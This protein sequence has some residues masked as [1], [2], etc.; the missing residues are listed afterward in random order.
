M[1]RKSVHRDTVF[2]DDGGASK[3]SDRLQR[4]KRK[5]LLRKLKY[6]AL[7]SCCILFYFVLRQNGDA[8]TDGIMDRRKKMRQIINNQ[9]MKRKDESISKFIRKKRNEKRKPNIE[10]SDSEDGGAN[11]DSNP[12]VMKY[13]WTTDSILPPV[14]GQKEWAAKF[15]DDN[16]K[17]IREKSDYKISHRR[18]KL[19]WEIEFEEME[20]KPPRVD[21][22]QHEY[23]YPEIIAQPPRGG[24]YPPME[25]L[26]ELLKRWPQ[27]NMD[28]PPSP[29]VEKLQHFDFNDEEQMKIAKLYRDLEF[30]F[31]LTNVPEL[32]AA[33]AKWTDD[34]LSYH[35]D[36]KRKGN[37]SY[38]EIKEKYSNIPPSSGHAQESVD[39][40]FAF[41]Q[42]RNWNTK[43]MGQPPT[44]D[45]DFTYERW[46]RHAKYADTVRLAQNET[47][48]YWQ[49]GASPSERTSPKEEW[50]MISVDLP[51]FSDTNPNFISFNPKE[52]KGIQCRFGE[53]GVAAATHYD[54]GRNMV[55]MITGA[56]RYVLAPP[57]E[58]GKVCFV[59]Q[60]FQ[61]RSNWIHKKITLTFYLSFL[62]RYRYFQ[63]AS[64]LQAFLTQL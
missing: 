39:S 4:R 8:V 44:K 17:P 29:Y 59:V 31:K 32:I 57:L 62:A 11:P 13:R 1:P 30:P 46:A 42:A 64:S 55:G 9:R 20:Q 60:S 19:P 26:G 61:F 45:N 6:P 49:S 3:N 16:G 21:Y 35:F 48:Y 23:D 33:N 5:I 58:C 10:L 41:Y 18:G 51:S 7:M 12:N 53:R 15:F 36:R 27:N 28:N 43:L 38:D 63:K 40:F 54:G 25:T 52:A 2:I 47:H 50:T 14:K 24:L 37:K 34:Y 22:T 56:K